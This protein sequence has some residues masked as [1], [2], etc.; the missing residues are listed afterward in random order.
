VTF[1][2]AYLILAFA[3]LL[4]LFIVLNMINTGTGFVPFLISLLKNK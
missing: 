2:T 4:K 3:E 1:G